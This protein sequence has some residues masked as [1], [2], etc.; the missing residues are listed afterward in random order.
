MV[1][2][3]LENSARGTM[4]YGARNSHTT[5]AAKRA[6]PMRRGARLCTL[7]QLYYELLALI[8][9]V[10]KASRTDLYCSPLQAHHE[11]GNTANA[12]STTNQIDLS[13]DIADSVIR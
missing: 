8:E 6:I 5:K 7:P 12:Q 1:L 10:M 9:Y 11:E 13:K 4:G 2:L 3:A